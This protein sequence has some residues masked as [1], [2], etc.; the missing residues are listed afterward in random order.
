MRV[1]A[2]LALLALAAPALS[3]AA[4]G[5]DDR[6][7]LALNGS[8]ISHADDGG[9]GSFAWLHNFNA[10]SILTVG[11]EYQTIAHSHWSFGTLNVTLGGGSAEHRSTFYGEAR[12]G[13]GNDGVQPF[14]VRQYQVGL[15]QNVTHQFALQFEDKQIDIARTRGNLPKFGLQMLW[16]PRLLTQVAYSHSVSG[17]LGTRLGSA[18]VDYYGKGFNIIAGGAGGKASPDIV[19]LHGLLQP[20]LT[21]REGF[22]GVGKT[23]SRVDLTLLGDYI[24][25]GETERVTVTLTGIVHLRG[26]ASK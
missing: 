11:G 26:G 8:T 25:I 21:L 3:K 2:T 16:S 13:S 22:A 4:P 20:G 24:K 14:D 7:A 10:N 1:A 6:L 23:F 9:G 19:D 12:V 17:N 5:A 18:R 15:I